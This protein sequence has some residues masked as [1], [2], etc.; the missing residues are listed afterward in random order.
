MSARKA[1]GVL[2]GALALLATSCAEAGPPEVSIYA[3]GEYTRVAPLK[4][5][6]VLIS[7]CQSAAD[8]QATLPIRPGEPVQVSVPAEIAEAPWLV[9]V[10]GVAADGTLLPVRQEF[11]SPGESYAYTARPTS[12][13]ERLLVVEVLQLGGAYAGG[14]DGK[15]ITDSE[16]NPQ[17]LARGWWSVGLA[18][19]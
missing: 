10:Q 12:P 9:N 5:C 19:R 7:D 18:A 16:G 14:E 13:G 4:Y 11:F 17:L 6:D 2:L 1:L 15:P 8:A 3:D